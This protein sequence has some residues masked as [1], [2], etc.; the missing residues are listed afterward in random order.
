MAEDT[1]ESGGGSTFM[2]TTGACVSQSNLPKIMKAGMLREKKNKFSEFFFVLRGDTRELLGY[3]KKQDDPV[4]PKD[5]PKIKI[6]LADC[7]GIRPITEKKHPFAFEVDLGKKKLVFATDAPDER[8]SWM[9][10]LRQF[11]VLHGKA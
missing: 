6:S 1:Y 7:Q 11:A 3:K 4:N 9:H 10:H 8:E 2:T 5:D